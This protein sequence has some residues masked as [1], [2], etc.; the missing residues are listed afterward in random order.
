MLLFYFLFLD[1][2]KLYQEIFFQQNLGKIY[3]FFNNIY[4]KELHSTL[5]IYIINPLTPYC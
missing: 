5:K 3:T 4:F 2:V 1:K